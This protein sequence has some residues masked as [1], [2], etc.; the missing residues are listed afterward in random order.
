MSDLEKY[1]D[2][3]DNNVNGLWGLQKAAAF[4][5]LKVEFRLHYLSLREQGLSVEAAMTAIRKDL[6]TLT[7]DQ[8]LDKWLLDPSELN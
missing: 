6:R 2:E 1:L 4:V 7:F 8:L 5:Q 3:I